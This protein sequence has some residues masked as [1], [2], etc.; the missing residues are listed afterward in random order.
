MAAML[1]AGGSRSAEVQDP[2]AGGVHDDRIADGVRSPPAAVTERSVPDGSN[3]WTRGVRPSTTYRR[4]PPDDVD[5]M[6]VGPCP[7]NLPGPVP[8]PPNCWTTVCPTCARITRCNPA[9][10]MK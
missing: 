2:L 1:P 4:P 10:A 6:P 8:G 9:E 5:A 3:V 7:A